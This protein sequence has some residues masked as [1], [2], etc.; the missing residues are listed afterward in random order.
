MLTYLL[1]LGVGL[2]SLGL[3]L[4]AFWFPLIYRNYDLTWSGVGLFYALVLWVCAGRITGGVLVGQLASVA[5]LGWFVWQ[6]L[7]LRWRQLPIAER[8][9]ELTTANSFAKVSQIKLKQLQES[10]Q[11]GSW[12]LVFYDRLDRAPA[13]V[14]IVIK[15]IQSWIEALLSTTL[16]PQPLEDEAIAFEIDRSTGDR[17][18]APPEDTAATDFAAVWDDLTL[19]DDPEME[20]VTGLEPS[21]APQT[22]SKSETPHPD[23][24]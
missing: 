6:T 23:S 21:P 9:L 2:G 15:T 11:D 18:A 22:V 5:L 10:F 3:Y 20:T 8:P 4:S 16:Q 1:A 19:E 13:Q 14:G 17:A 12:K 7:D 24:L